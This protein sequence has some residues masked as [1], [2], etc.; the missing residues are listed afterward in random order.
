MEATYLA[1]A[2]KQFIELITQTHKDSWKDDGHHL[3]V[4]FPIQYKE[5]AMDFL[6]ACHRVPWPT[7]D[8]Q[9]Q[10]DLIRLHFEHH[11]FILEHLKETLIRIG[12][13]RQSMV[14]F[15]CPRSYLQDNPEDIETVFMYIEPH[16]FAKYKY[17]HLWIVEYEDRDSNLFSVMPSPSSAKSLYAGI[18]YGCI[19]GGTVQHF[20]VGKIDQYQ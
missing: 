8:I 14:R 19:R 9:Y 13:S 7:M 10:D 12:V 20:S 3:V 6:A 4:F 2:I 11:L 17:R 15:S 16:V 1:Y 5:L 18:N